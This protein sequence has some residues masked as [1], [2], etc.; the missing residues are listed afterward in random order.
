MIL[1]PLRGGKTHQMRKKNSEKLAVVTNNVNLRKY[2][3]H[4]AGIAMH[5]SYSDADVYQNFIYV[6]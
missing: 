3:T 5:R 4:P 1:G 6:S 2:T